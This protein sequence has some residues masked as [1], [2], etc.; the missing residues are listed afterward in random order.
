[1]RHALRLDDDQSPLFEHHEELG[2]S[3]GEAL[4]AAAHGLLP[5]GAASSRSRQGHGARYR[6]GTAE[7]TFREMLP[8]GLGAHFDSST[9]TV[10]PIF[11]LLQE[12]Q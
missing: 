7:T 8:E 10:P 5:G 12:T 1:M 6:R 3:I 2:G 9:W 11:T 4:L